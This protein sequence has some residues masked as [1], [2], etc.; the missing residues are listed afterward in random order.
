MA[1]IV[2]AALV[3]NRQII[4]QRVDGILAFGHGLRHQVAA[5]L[6]HVTRHQFSGQIRQFIVAGYCQHCGAL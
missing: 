4:Q 1:V 3:V 5:L 2:G 6:Q